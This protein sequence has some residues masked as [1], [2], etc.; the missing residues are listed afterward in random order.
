MFEAELLNIFS[1]GPEKD[2][3]G[4]VI[5]FTKINCEVGDKM[6]CSSHI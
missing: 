4:E 6:T 5:V 1:N 2:M 3:S